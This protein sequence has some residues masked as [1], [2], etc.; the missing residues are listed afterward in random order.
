MNR[1][2]R[3]TLAVRLTTTRLSFAILLLTFLTVAV[4]RTARGQGATCTDN[5][6][7]YF[8]KFVI[9]YKG[10]EYA[11]QGNL[12]PDGGSGYFLH[13]VYA[14]STLLLKS[15]AGNPT[16]FRYGVPTVTPN[17]TYPCWFD[18]RIPFTY[19]ANKTTAARN[20]GW[21]FTIRKD[22][23]A[24]IYDT[25]PYRVQQLPIDVTPPT[26]EFVAPAA[27]EVLKPP[28]LVNSSVINY[29]IIFD[30]Y[31]LPSDEGGYVG[32][33]NG[34]RVLLRNSAGKYWYSKGDF[35]NGTNNWVGSPP[36]PDNWSYC[37]CLG[38]PIAKTHIGLGANP[39]LF[40]AGIYTIIIEAKDA[41]GNR[42]K[43]E[44]K[45]K[46][47]IHAP[48]TLTLSAPAAD[49]T[50]RA[51]TTISG[52][53]GD[54]PNGVGIDK[55]EIQL[56]G[57][58]GYWNGSAWLN[59]R[60]CFGI[61]LPLP[62]VYSGGKWNTTGALPSG[63]KLPPG[64]YSTLIIAYDKAGNRSKYINSYFRVST[65]AIEV[66]LDP[67]PV[68]NT[69]V[70]TNAPAMPP[71]KAYAKVV[72]LTPD[73][74]S[75]TQFTWKAELQ[76]REGTGALIDLSGDLVQNKTT[77]GTAQLPLPLSSAGMLRGGYLTFTAEAV[78]NGQTLRASTPP[79][80]INGQNPLTSNVRTAI[81]SQ[82]ATQ[83]GANYLGLPL[84]QARD[85]LKRMA[86]H[87]SGG[88]N[89]GQKQF[90][91]A[92]NTGSGVP[93]I[94]FDNGA[95]IFQVTKADSACT[96]GIFNPYLANPTMRNLCRNAV[97]NWQTNVQ[98]GV[99]I[100]KEKVRLAKGYPQSL[101]TNSQYRAYI[102]QKINPAR[103]AA[104]LPE[105]PIQSSTGVSLPLPAPDFSQE[106]LRLDT[107]RAFNGYGTMRLWGALL[108]EYRPSETALKTKTLAQLQDPA[109]FWERVPG[110]AAARGT[111]G[112]PDY[113]NKI[114]S[115]PATCTTTTT[116]SAESVTAGAPAQEA[117]QTQGAQPTI[118]T[119]GQTVE[120]KFP[121]MLDPEQAV[122]AVRYS[123]THNMRSARV[124]SVTYDFETR[125]VRLTLSEP[126][127][128]WDE[129][130]VTWDLMDLYAS[131]LKGEAYRQ[132]KPEDS[133]A[134]E[135]AQPEA[136]PE[137]SLERE[138]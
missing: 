2:R 35:L 129:V 94:S 50:V 118:S 1:S 45:F 98:L 26:L 126:V 110:T 38:Y 36:E 7:H 24:E 93:L 44:R 17:P 97:F 105:I 80:L 58:Q 49:S 130:V 120:L 113:V 12:R 67:A 84:A 121:E 56:Q 128:E 71:I 116:T 99:T 108:H 16:W 109:V 131:P 88:S 65:A 112:A 54:Q 135:G 53:A 138:P 29:D 21:S 82:S 85:A 57:S 46:L 18:Y 69:Y 92:P 48:T 14:G 62:T 83:L 95:G 127:R 68:S 77:T 79:I 63:A 102:V 132:V 64:A 111:M 133:G 122:D 4:P 90:T 10:T 76:T 27:G 86:C 52:L 117:K 31:T 43:R 60:V 30:Y 8:D 73:P 81:D 40:P 22:S 41:A 137:R 104:S 19:D 78:V 114:L 72:G 5:V 107:I 32:S 6:S 89:K 11:T 70:I 96:L 33:H 28:Y 119:E 37:P 136:M 106:Q 74:T 91:A 51:L 103:K 42:T 101:R 55:V 25:P 115:T 124:E 59:D 39:A 34:F 9:I 87:E 20:F 125:T 15:D 3:I 75:T 61:C 100:F 23:T 134:G 47:D 13:R 123:V 66:K